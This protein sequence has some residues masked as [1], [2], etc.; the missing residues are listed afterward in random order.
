M[1]RFSK[2]TG[3]ARRAT[4]PAAATVLLA[5]ALSAIG[6][7]SARADVSTSAWY[8][9]VANNSG[10]CVDAASAATANGTAVQQYTCNGTTAQQWQ[11]RPAADAGTYVIVNANGAQ[12]AIDVDG[13]STASGALI[14]LWS[15]GGWSSQEWQPV[16][17]SSG[18]YHFVNHYSGLC[19]DVPSAS[20]ADSVQLQQYTC[21]GTNAQSF[22]LNVVSGGSTPPNNPNNPDLGPN[23]KVFDPSMPAS[24]IQS[25]VNSVYSSQ[26][27][28]QFGTN[29]Y[30]LLFKPGSYNVD[31]PVG[32]YT[33]VA[34]L[35]ASPD[36]VS[37]T[38][39]GVHVDAAWSGGNAT[40]NFWRDVENLSDTPSSGT[41][42]Y[43]VSQADPFRRVDVHG[44]MTLDDY[45]SGNTSSNWSSGGFIGDS[46]VSGQINSGTQQQFLTQDT[47]MGSWSGSN[48]NMVFVGDNGAPGQ[49]FPTYTTVAQTPTVREKPYL[50]VD[51]TG[52]YN[53]MVPALRTNAT[54]P[55]WTGGSTAGTSIP[56]TQ[57]YV[58]K[59]GDTA[60]SINAALSS[61]LNLLFTPGVYHL[62]APLNITRKDTVVLGLG[63]ATLVPDNGVTAITTADVDGIDIAGLI[64]S[65][66]TTNSGS[67]VQIGPAGS[68]ASHAA[69]PIT[70]QDVFF[71]V[72][73]DVAG[74]ASQSLVVNSANTI[75][76]DLWIWRADH[77]N[78]GTVGWTVNTAANGLVV[79]G[80][81][82]TMY[83]LAVEHYQQYQTLWNGNGGRTYFYQSEM[84]YDVPNNASW[85]PGG[86]EAGY[87]SY[88]VAD[89]VTSHQAWGLGVYCYFSTNSAV[90]ADRAIEVPSGG[91]SFHDMVTVSLGGT[92][93]IRHIINGAGGQVSSG[94]T[95]AYL[96]AG[97]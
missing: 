53:V 77:G 15:N 37:L 30:A 47:T 19:L 58:V 74:K 40:Q 91:S 79:N 46:R 97:P 36:D 50:Y 68:S 78:G 20:T 48:W 81:N 31:V 56:I 72:G 61:G 41:L 34:G 23:V 45:T 35:G 57:F 82:V 87:P 21:N 67:L 38:G 5:A 13:P 84:P 95:V 92:G 9:L 89:S 86:G 42:E 10:K 90:A 93:T 49:S 29:R 88:K 73:G 7:G 64:V 51:S 96:T 94:S 18:R 8:N 85:T 44:S 62:S 43:A 24:S 26:Q 25:A 60:A 17:E 22:A 6:S 14:H 52:L 2:L 4:G 66:G 54:G 16:Q 59:S 63:L 80:A 32:F 1:K 70:L 55:D 28:D 76:S 33:Q 69:D 83:G 65:A 11:L 71:R 3:S 39:G 75:G 27:S 12:P